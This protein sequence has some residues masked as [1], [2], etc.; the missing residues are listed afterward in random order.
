MKQEEEEAKNFVIF[1]F[2][3]H[4]SDKSHTRPL[5]KHDQGATPSKFIFL[6]AARP[7]LPMTL[8]CRA[9]W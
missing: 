5:R 3:F 2:F 6:A 9:R 4:F 8:T 7:L 1:F